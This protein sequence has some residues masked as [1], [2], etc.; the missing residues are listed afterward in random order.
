MGTFHFSLQEFSDILFA[1]VLL[2][3][4]TVEEIL[5]TYFLRLGKPKSFSV[6]SIPISNFLLFFVNSRLQFFE[7]EIFYR[8]Q[9]RCILLILEI[10]GF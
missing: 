7:V 8:D 5:R 9:K 6:V 10:N 2:T 1:R 3:D 4:E